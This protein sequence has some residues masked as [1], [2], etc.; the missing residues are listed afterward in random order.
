MSDA[1]TALNTTLRGKWNE[2]HAQK[3]KVD[4]RER[5]RVLLQA[6]EEIDHKDCAENSKIKHEEKSN[7]GSVGKEEVKLPVNSMNAIL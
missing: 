7:S 3:E 4:V 5:I 1:R 6:S 2:R